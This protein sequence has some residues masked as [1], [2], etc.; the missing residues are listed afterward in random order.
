MVGTLGKEELINAVN[1]NK[2]SYKSQIEALSSQIQILN[3]NNQQVTSLVDSDL[4]SIE[5]VTA[6]VIDSTGHAVK[7]STTAVGYMFHGI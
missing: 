3:G 7:D 4:D 2:K 5:E 1:D 6:K